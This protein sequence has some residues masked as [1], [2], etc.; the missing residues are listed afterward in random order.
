MNCL[1]VLETEYSLPKLLYGC[2]EGLQS[3]EST[4]KIWVCTKNNYECKSHDEQLA[5]YWKWSTY[6]L[7]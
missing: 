5:E 1:H 7:S 4:S 6:W 2:G 3:E